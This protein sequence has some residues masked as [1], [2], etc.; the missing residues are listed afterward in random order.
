MAPPEE[1]W[2]NDSLL[3]FDGRVL[4]VFGVSGSESLRF[5]VDNVRIDVGEPGRRDRRLLQLKPRT[6]GGGGCALEIEEAD[7]EKAGPLLER[8]RAAGDPPPGAAD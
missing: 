6:L 2:I 1:V 8:V 7:W 5:H 3:V 4:E